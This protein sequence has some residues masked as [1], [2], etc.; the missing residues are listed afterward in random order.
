MDENAY[1]RAQ[2]TK[3]KHQVQT[4]AVPLS[5]RPGHLCGEGIY[6]SNILAELMLD[7]LILG[8]MTEH[9]STFLCKGMGYAHICHIC[10]HMSTT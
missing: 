1:L 2:P 4:W 7:V 10:M 3:H 8:E 5:L 9:L 6:F